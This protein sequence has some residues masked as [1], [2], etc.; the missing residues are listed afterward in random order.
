M[1]LLGVFKYGFYY[2]PGDSPILVAGSVLPELS[3]Q[4]AGGFNQTIILSVV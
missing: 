4:G 3:F 2:K 1:C